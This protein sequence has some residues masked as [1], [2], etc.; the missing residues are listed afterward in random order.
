MRG[1]INKDRIIEESLN[2]LNEKSP[3]E[4]TIKELATRLDIKSSSLYK[5]FRNLEALHDLLTTYS[6]RQLLNHLN[7]SI[8]SLEGREALRNLFIAYRAFALQYPSL[9]EYTQNTSY[10]LSDES[11]AISNQIVELIESL[12]TN[13]KDTSD[14]IEAIRFFRSYVTGFVHLELHD[15]FGLDQAVDQSFLF[16]LEKSLELIHEQGKTQE[17]YERT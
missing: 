5:H 15:G 13:D 6:L 7:Q 17:R 8:Q 4:L 12:L 9:Y 16:G 2:I 10:W 14:K 3:E 11:M 1:K